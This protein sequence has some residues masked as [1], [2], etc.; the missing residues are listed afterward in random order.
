MDTGI[1]SLFRMI[2]FRRM[3]PACILVYVAVLVPIGLSG[4]KFDIN[5]PTRF[6]VQQ[7]SVTGL[8]CVNVEHA[9]SRLECALE[10]VRHSV[11]KFAFSFPQ[12]S[13]WICRAG[14]SYTGN[15]QQEHKIHEAFHI[16]GWWRCSI[17]EY[18]MNYLYKIHIKTNAVFPFRWR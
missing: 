9:R 2:R 10:T 5:T 3:T 6:A 4:S 18:Y 12:R 1:P 13:C 15:T 8:F 11:Y 7:R 14:G 16:K 17:R